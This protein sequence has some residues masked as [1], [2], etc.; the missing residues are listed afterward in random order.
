MICKLNQFILLS[1]C[2]SIC[3]SVEFNRLNFNVLNDSNSIVNFFEA[4]LL[5]PCDSDEQCHENDINSVCKPS[6]NDP[7]SNKTC[8][9]G[10]GY[11]QDSDQCLPEFDGLESS[12]IVN[13]NRPITSFLSKIYMICT[14]KSTNSSLTISN[15]TFQFESGKIKSEIYSGKCTNNACIYLLINSFLNISNMFNLDID[16][17]DQFN[18]KCIITIGHF[19]S[20][21]NIKV[22]NSSSIKIIRGIKL[23]DKF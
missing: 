22:V 12:Y 15:V 20:S 3:S 2:L 4:D 23:N 1:F 6:G 10:F 11:Y 5:E 14:I 21:T 7:D 8:Q 19:N 9:C 17:L 13:S 16:H 18:S